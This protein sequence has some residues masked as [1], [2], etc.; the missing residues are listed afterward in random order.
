MPRSMASFMASRMGAGVS[1]SGSP[2]AKP[3][4][5]TPWLRSSLAL[6]SMA[7]VAEGAI[8]LHFLDSPSGMAVSSL[9]RH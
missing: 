2:A 6:A 9:L 8:A 5:L 7:R 4:T 1:K 3:I